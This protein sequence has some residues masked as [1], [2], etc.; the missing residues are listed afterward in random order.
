MSEVEEQNTSQVSEIKINEL[1]DRC[2]VRLDGLVS[3]DQFILLSQELN[4]PINKN[5]SLS[6]DYYPLSVL[7]Q[8][9]DQSQ[10]NSQSE[11]NL[12]GPFLL[13][14]KASTYTKKA[15]V[16][17]LRGRQSLTYSESGVVDDQGVPSG[18]E[19]FRKEFELIEEKEREEK[20]REKKEKENE[21]GKEA[22]NNNK[23]E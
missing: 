19:L 9:V 8:L 1:F 2:E 13:A 20:E 17:A 22:E 6:E 7:V 15:R 21:K 10:V 3:K 4:I 16:T 12:I 14:R 11:S 23:K 5:H 18:A